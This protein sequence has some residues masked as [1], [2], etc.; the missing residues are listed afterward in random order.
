MQAQFV[1]PGSAVDADDAPAFQQAVEML[2]A[3]GKLQ[4]A[5]DGKLRLPRYEDELEGRDLSSLYEPFCQ[6]QNKILINYRAFRDSI[7]SKIKQMEGNFS[8][9]SSLMTTQK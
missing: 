7:V 9:S 5:A 1:A 6:I 4:L 8:L 2:V 3:E